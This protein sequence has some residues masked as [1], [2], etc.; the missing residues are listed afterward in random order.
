M[1]PELAWK[2]LGKQQK[3]IRDFLFSG[4]KSKQVTLILIL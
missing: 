2:I 4:G 3:A 1:F